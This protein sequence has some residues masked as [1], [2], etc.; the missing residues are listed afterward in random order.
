MIQPIERAGAAAVRLLDARARGAELDV[1]DLQLAAWA[2]GKAQLR[3]PSLPDPEED[4]PVR[5]AA[6]FG[7]GDDEAGFAI[8]AENISLYE[9]HKLLMYAC[10]LVGD[11]CADTL[12]EHAARHPGVWFSG[13]MLTRTRD[14]LRLLALADASEI[15]SHIVDTVGELLIRGRDAGSSIPEIEQRW[16]ELNTPVARPGYLAGFRDLELRVAAREDMESA[17][18]WMQEY[19]GPWGYDTQHWG[20][21]AVLARLVRTDPER[22]CRIVASR[23][24]PANRVSWLWPLVRWHE[25][26]A[27][28]E[29]MID[30]LLAEDVVDVDVAGALIDARSFDR[31][32]RALAK[33]DP[34]D[35][36]ALVA[37]VARPIASLRDAGLIDD[38][39]AV[40]DRVQSLLPQTAPPGEVA[41]RDLLDVLSAPERPPLV[42]WNPDPGLP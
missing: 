2:V 24:D 39:E 31:L 28:A 35:A 3:L 30:N 27:A 42:P 25:L 32:A 21:L 23:E 16:A 20:N 7:A 40:R 5:Q 33:V 34:S 41:P 14:P 6:A 29:P 37:A 9:G 15:E 22:A 1:M 26:P 4:L 36:F 10:H 8:L 11:R 17:I 12:L 13:S 19:A 18:R 38:A